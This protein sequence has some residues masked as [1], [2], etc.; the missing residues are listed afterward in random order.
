MDEATFANLAEIVL[1]FFVPGAILAIIQLFRI[2]RT[3][4]RTISQQSERMA[5]LEGKLKVKEK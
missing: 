5:I 1:I 3:M 2:V 4:H